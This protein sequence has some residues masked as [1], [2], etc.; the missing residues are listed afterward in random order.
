MRIRQAGALRLRRDDRTCRDRVSKPVPRRTSTLVDVAQAAGVSVSTAGRVLRGAA[1][2]ADA[3]LRARVVAAAAQVGY[4]ANLAARS[5]RDGKRTM[6]GLVVGDMLDPYY[7]EVAEAFTQRAEEA[8]GQLA[9]V[10]NMQR[11]PLLELKYCRQLWEHRVA[12]IVLAGGGFDQWTHLGRLSSLVEQ[13]LGAGVRVATL[14]P[15]NLAAPVF[16]ADNVEVGRTMA[17]AVVSRG[18][19]VIG[20]MLGPPQSE[21]TQRRLQGVMSQLGNLRVSVSHSEY[22][23]G[24]GRAATID[25]LA[26]DPAITALLVGSDA[27]A[28]GV[29]DQLRT[30]DRRVPEDVSVVSIGNAD[31]FAKGDTDAASAAEARRGPRLTTVDVGLARCGEAALDYIVGGA[32]ATGH[33]R[34]ECALFEGET[35]GDCIAP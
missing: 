1:Q 26:R 2:P 20:V 13:M 4:V 34:F 27:M 30:M 32:E 8:H 14:S 28:Y 16:S 9:L 31:G 21:V 11:D 29:V 12:G 18:H 23:Y 33:G 3:A 25:L 6:V 24:A 35:L 10:C 17:A 7:A 15:R 19:R 22:R 5:L